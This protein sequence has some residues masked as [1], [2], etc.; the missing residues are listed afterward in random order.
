MTER[1]ERAG[2]TVR[3]PMAF[4]SPAVHS[5]LRYLA[6]IGFA[7]CEALARRG[8]EPQAGWIREGSLERF[9]AQITWTE[10]CGL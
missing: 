10:S 8:I 3:R 7:T 9:R 6:S 5:L 1:V 2:D 4:W